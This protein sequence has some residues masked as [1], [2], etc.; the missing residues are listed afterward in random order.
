MRTVA[1]VV[2]ALN[3]LCGCAAVLNPSPPAVDGSQ[4]S[5]ALPV[6]DPRLN[7]TLWQQTSA[8][9]RVLVKTIY[10]MAKLQLDRA[11]A[12][13]EW[14]AEPTQRDGFQNLPPAVIM[15]IDET[16]LDNSVFQARLIQSGAEYSDSSWKG[17]IKEAGAAS[18][19]GS[20]DFV[21]FAQARNVTVFFVTSR[22]HSEEQE[23]RT[24]LRS[25]GISLPEDRDTVL[26]RGERSD[27]G[28]DKASRRQFIAHSYRVL[29]VIGDDLADF[30]SSYR[31]TPS[32]R[33]KDALSRNGWG[34]KW[35]LLPNAV[36]G[37]WI[38]SLHD[39][40]FSL[41]RDE[42]LNRQIKYLRLEPSF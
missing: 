9:Y 1:S 25:V 19:A 17:W 28:S 42:I 32:E 27:W 11:L 36:Y 20:V 12:D 39:F 21:S 38:E 14:T 37:S 2:L 35:F 18:V 33:I 30:T 29:L 16:I 8:E 31:G 24:Q 22:P 34:T 6:R 10:A 3:I 26:M 5:A 4:Y 13:G 40:D 41:T 23:T 7:A 15:D